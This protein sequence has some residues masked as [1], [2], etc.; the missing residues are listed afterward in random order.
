MSK[1]TKPSHE[2]AVTT[3]ARRIALVLITRYWLTFS[4]IWIFLWG[5]TVLSLRVATNLS[6]AQLLWGLAGLAPALVMA[7]IWGR[8][9]LPSRS[10]IRALVDHRGDFGGLL[11]AS[12]QAE[13]GEWKSM[14]PHAVA[15]RVRLRSARQ[16]GLLFV[17]VAFLVASFLAPVRF[18]V[19]ASDRPLDVEQQA[20]QLKS[21]IETLKKEEMIEEPRAES[22]EERLDAIKK[23]ASGEDP[24][25]TWEALDHLQDSVSDAAQEGA[26]KLAQ[27]NEN[28]AKAQ[29]LSE[30]LAGAGSSMDP[31]LAAEAMKELSSLME[32]AMSDKEALEKAL[33]SELSSSLKSG[34][35]SSEQ[36]K[37]LAKA[38]GT[39]KGEIAK[40]LGK[41]REARLIDAEAL[42]KCENAGK[43]DSAGLAEFLKDNAGEMSVEEAVKLW[44]APG[45]GGVDRGRGDAEMTWTDPSSE[46]GTKFKE[47]V[48]PPGGIAGLKD[49]QL[50]GRSIGAPSI[51]HKGSAGSGALSG[52]NAG[53]GSAFTQTILPRHKG[54]VKRYFDRP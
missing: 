21:D 17:S 50:A 28:L 20:D 39:R 46:K 14:L 45:R 5:V 2:R 7:F 12:A 53:G 31:K 43:C 27:T 26:E 4:I 8:K 29:A 36:L 16:G 1:D 32:S 9:G 25:K 54:S 52:A 49:S 30:A 18:G 19:L 11:M 44:G 3:F 6:K 42:K 35:L 51:D 47:E 37:Q 10:A 41:L 33:G 34:S 23:D 40:R 22:L 24:V 48:L 38:L 15:P 13:L